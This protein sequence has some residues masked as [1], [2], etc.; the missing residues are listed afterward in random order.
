[1]NIKFN[2]LKLFSGDTKANTSRTKTCTWT[3]QTCI[4][5]F[6]CFVDLI[7]LHQL[8][9]LL[10]TEY[11]A[12]T[13]TYRELER[14]WKEQTRLFK[15]TITKDWHG[16]CSFRDSNWVLLECKSY[17]LLLFQTS[18]VLSLTTYSCLCSWGAGFD[19]RPECQ[20]ILNISNFP[21]SLYA[22]RPK[23]GHNEFLSYS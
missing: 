6:Y 14:I 12:I 8:Q 1:V 4:F 23:V 22:W 15:Y 2:T 13:V 17:L 3:L 9:R 5:C 7:K 21:Q 10:S 19:S 11:G 18:F 16:R 20:D